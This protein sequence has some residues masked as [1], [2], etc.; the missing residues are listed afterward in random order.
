MFVLR[1]CRESWPLPPP[2]LNF[3]FSSFF[4]FMR[5]PPGNPVQNSGERFVHVSILAN[6]AALW[7]LSWR[8]GL[9]FFFFF[10]C[11]FFFLLAQP[12]LLRQHLIPPSTEFIS[13]YGN[14]HVRL[15]GWYRGIFVGFVI[16]SSRVQHEFRRRS[17]GH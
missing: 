11:F 2:G 16:N 1:V 10:F 7:R 12:H 5:R 6:L 3:F 17:D 9:T 4:L 13:T 8:A 15:G 14:T